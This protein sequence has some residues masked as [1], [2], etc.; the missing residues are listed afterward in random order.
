ML[1]LSRRSGEEV[2]IAGNIRVRII[3]AERNRVRIGIVA[4]PSVTVNRKEIHDHLA[5]WASQKARPK[6]GRLD[7]Q[8]RGGNLHSGSPHT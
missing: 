3:A 2:V 5:E 7:R 6:S 8:D 1:V 4:P